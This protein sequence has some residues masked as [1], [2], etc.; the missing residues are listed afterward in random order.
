MIADWPLIGSRI[1]IETHSDM[2]NNVWEVEKA[3]QGKEPGGSKVRDVNQFV[4]QKGEEL[5]VRTA[6]VIPP[7]ICKFFLFFGDGNDD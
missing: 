2:R 4:A 5:G 1:D 7:L 3:L 6:I